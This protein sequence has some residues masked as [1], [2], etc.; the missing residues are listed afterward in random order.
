MV[1]SSF[2]TENLPRVSV[3]DGGALC[4]WMY[5]LLDVFR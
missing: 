4:G 5:A 3:V 1:S 2:Q